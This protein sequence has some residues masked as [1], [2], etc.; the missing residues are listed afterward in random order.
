LVTG[1]RLVVLPHLAYS[2]SHGFT[3]AA[4]AL[5]LFALFTDFVDG[6]LARTL[7][8]TSKFGAY[9]DVTVD[10]LFVFGLFS[11]FVKEGLY[12][13]WLLAPMLLMYLQFL[14]TSVYWRKVVYDP[15]G[16]YFGSLLFGGV[17]LTLLFPYQITYEIVRLGILVSIV[18]SVVSRLAYLLNT[19]KK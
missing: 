10:F 15:A 17:G 4:Y 1:L 6:R 5:F 11:Q 8:A 3:Y 19:E 7:G 16:K 2:F 14:V 18:I 9:F 12:S 13:A